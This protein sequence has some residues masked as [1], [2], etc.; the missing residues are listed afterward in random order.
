MALPA[1]VEAEINGTP[2]LI[3]TVDHLDGGLVVDGEAFALPH[4]WNRTEA[5]GW[6]AEIRIRHIDLEVRTF[7]AGAC[8]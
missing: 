5:G 7:K 2:V 4:A 1:R 3:A 6:H 8:A